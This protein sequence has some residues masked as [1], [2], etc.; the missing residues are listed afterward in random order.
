MTNDLLT[1]EEAAKYLTLFPGT[2]KQWRSQQRGP[3]YVKVGGRVR[4]RRDAL[5][6]FLQSRE[7]D[8]ARAA[9]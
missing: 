6:E 7:I 1:P 3:R 5:D 2:L 8:P 9:V 4:Y